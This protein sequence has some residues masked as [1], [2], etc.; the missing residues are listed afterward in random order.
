MLVYFK[1]ASYNLNMKHMSIDILAIYNKNLK[2]KMYILKNIPINN[3]YTNIHEIS[4]ISLI[5]KNLRGQM[6]IYSIVNNFDL[7]M[8]I[9]SSMY[10]SKRILQHINNN[11]SN[12]NL[13]NAFNK[14]KL[15]N[16]TL[17]ILEFLP[18]DNNLT[19]IDYN[20]ELTR[21]EQK[22]L[23]LFDNKYNIKPIAGRPRVKVQHTKDTK[24]TVK[25]KNP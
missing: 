12:V 22:Y 16:F 14:Y 10:L 21:M 19:N 15:E 7:K 2:N 3:I 9:G 17:Y 13:Q 6:G 11:S 20:V 5:K 24:S 23:D 18:L 25:P 1:A 8:Y 4:T